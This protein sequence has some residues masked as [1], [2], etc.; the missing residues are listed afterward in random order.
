MKI[1]YIAYSIWTYNIQ[2]T[3]PL[4]EQSYYVVCIMPIIII[5]TF[6]LY[7]VVFMTKGSVVVVH[8]TPRLLPA[9][10]SL[11]PDLVQVGVDVPG[12]GGGGGG[13]VE[14][15]RAHAAAGA[16][17]AWPR[18]ARLQAGARRAGRRRAARAGLCAEAE[19][20]YDIVM[21]LSAAGWGH[22]T[23][24]HSTRTCYLVRQKLRSAQYE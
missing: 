18:V 23:P 6:R 10:G 20:S 17:V 15:L 13:G 2:A 12:E 22:L 9:L 14:A 24:S 11:G 16:G 3:G 5:L 19:G 4:R 1:I 7:L 21:S 8:P